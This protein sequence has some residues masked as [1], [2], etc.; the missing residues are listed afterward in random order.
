MILV[1]TSVWVDHFRKADAQL[2]VLLDKALVLAHPFVIGEIAC[3]H[4]ANRQHVLAL[5]ESLPMAAVAQP[6]EV[7][8]YIERHRVYGKGIGFVDAQLLASTALTHGAAL[9]TRDQRLHAVA[10]ALG[11]AYSPIPRTR[12]D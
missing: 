11:V 8:R 4:L 9:W 6:H 2:A 10:R 7:L 3:G 1:D 5:L 12:A